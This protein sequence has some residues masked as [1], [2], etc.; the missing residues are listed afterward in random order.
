MVQEKLINIAWIHYPPEVQ[1]AWDE[2]MEMSKKAN[3][4][5]D[6]VNGHCGES[7]KKVFAQ[8]A[9]LELTAY[10]IMPPEYSNLR[11][12]I[13]ATA[14]RYFLEA[15]QVEMSRDLSLEVLGNPSLTK[16]PDLEYKLASL[17]RDIETARQMERPRFSLKSL[18]S[19]LTEQYLQGSFAD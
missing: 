10:K 15:G 18:E 4:L 1:N 9:D 7:V 6:R 8:A 16:Y 11:G 3:Q 14:A 12:V 5:A 17:F 19:R 2:A 13:G